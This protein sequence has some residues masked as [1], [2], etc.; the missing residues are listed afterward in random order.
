MKP[1]V[2]VHIPFCEQR[3]YYC[4]FTVAVAGEQTYEP[5]VRRLI[6][7]IELA[8]WDEKPETIFLGGGT[9]SLIDGELIARLLAAIPQGA[10]E[11][12]LEANPGTLT[13]RKLETYRRNAINRISLGAQS[14]DDQDLKNAGRLHTSSDVRRDFENLRKH[15]FTNIGI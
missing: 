3:C 12:S 14:F 7:E 13:D 5:Y 9:P 4:A 10:V 15:G 2:Y 1:G 8:E 11:V 6:R